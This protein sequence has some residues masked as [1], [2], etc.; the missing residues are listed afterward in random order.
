MNIKQVLRSARYAVTRGWKAFGKKWLCSAAPPVVVAGYQD[1]LERVLRLSDL[2]RYEDLKDM[3][4]ADSAEPMSTPEPDFSDLHEAATAEA[5]F[6][7]AGL[8]A[9]RI[10]L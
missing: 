4:S 10:F 6:E 9:V 2:P 7:A 5:A 3:D 1:Q 8:A